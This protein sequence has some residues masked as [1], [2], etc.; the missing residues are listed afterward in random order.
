MKIVFVG[1]WF[2]SC[3]KLFMVLRRVWLFVMIVCMISLCFMFVRSVGI[4]LLMR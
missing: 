2:M 3:E 1:N 4:W